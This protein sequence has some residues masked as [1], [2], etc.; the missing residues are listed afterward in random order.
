[1]SLLRRLGKPETRERQELRLPVPPDEA[2]AAC[3]AALAEMNWSVESPGPGRLRSREDISMLHCGHAPMDLEVEVRQAERGG[4]IVDAEGVVA[5]AGA[6]ASKHL[7]Q[8]MKAFVR[9]MA[10]HALVTAP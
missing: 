2:L 7:S 1:M 4:S 9:V 3:R 5:G 10:R 6:V 8:A